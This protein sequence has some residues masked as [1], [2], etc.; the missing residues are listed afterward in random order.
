VGCRHLFSFKLGIDR[1]F[2]DKMHK[3]YD[4]T[5]NGLIKKMQKQE[6]EKMVKDQG[7][8]YL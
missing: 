7:F 5:I 4:L 1:D 2:M 6:W 3:P 8:V